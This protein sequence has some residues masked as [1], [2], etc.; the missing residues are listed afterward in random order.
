VTAEPETGHTLADK[1]NRLFDT[2]RRPDGKPHTNEEVAAFCRERTGEPFSRA[3]MSQLRKGERDNPTKRNLAA[4]A[5]FFDVSPA[6]FFDDDRSRQI[7]VELDL[8]AAL[9][10]KKVRQVALRAVNLDAGDLAVVADMIESIGR[11]RED[12]AQ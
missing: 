5:A 2:I 8:L 11:R 1:L 3:Y 10:D 9:R 12:T 6:Y 7:A 4:L